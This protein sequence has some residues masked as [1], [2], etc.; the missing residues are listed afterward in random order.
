MV[1]KR[2]NTQ[3][4]KRAAGRPGALHVTGVYEIAK[5]N[6]VIPLGSKVYWNDTAKQAVP[7]ATGNAQLGIAVLDAAANDATVLVRIG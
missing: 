7:D 4:V 5:A 2:Q 3:K 1:S 6:V